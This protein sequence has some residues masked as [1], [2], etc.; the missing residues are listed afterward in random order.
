MGEV[1]AEV[2]TKSISFQAKDLTLSP[3]SREKVSRSPRYPFVSSKTSQNL[4]SQ[5][6]CDVKTSSERKYVLKKLGGIF[7]VESWKKLIGS[8]SDEALE[9]D[10]FFV[11]SLFEH[12]ASC[13]KP[14]FTSIINGIRAQLSKYQ[15]Q[16]YRFY[17]LP[18]TDQ[19]YESMQILSHLEDSFSEG[20]DL[21]NDAFHTTSLQNALSDIQSGFHRP[22]S[23]FPIE[24]RRGTIRHLAQD[25]VDQTDLVKQFLSEDHE[26]YVFYSSSSRG[27]ISPQVSLYSQGEIPVVFWTSKEE[28]SKTS[29]SQMAGKSNEYQGEVRLRG[30][31]PVRTSKVIF[32]NLDQILATDLE[33]LKKVAPV[34]D[35]RLLHFIDLLTSYNNFV[36][37]HVDPTLAV[38]MD[39]PK[40]EFEIKPS[41]IIIKQLGLNTMETIKY[42][43]DSYTQIQKD[44][45]QIERPV[46]PW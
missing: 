37:P 2:A 34:Y 7:T 25:K 32:T 15:G 46:L 28:L 10:D 45:S 22:S 35:V 4:A 33:Q 8:F 26:E 30:K 23:H 40:G 39:L 36:M 1:G 24:D 14:A 21:V 12:L 42:Y 29:A 44:S 13:D 9:Y 31:V 43:V 6:D 11:K 18:P 38:T 5:A 19:I 41:H 17:E 20:V 27:N 3:P 16:I